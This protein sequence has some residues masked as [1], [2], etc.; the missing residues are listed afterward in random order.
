MSDSHISKAQNL[1]RIRDN[2]RRSR[3]RRKEYLQELEAKLRSCEQQGIEASAE[4]QSAARKV[5]EENKKLR[6]LLR[7][8][9]VPEAEIVAVM[10]GSND[11]PFEHI[12]AAPTLHNMLERKIACNVPSSIDS[13]PSMQ[14]NSATLAPRA[15]A[16]PPITI[17]PH[18]SATLNDSPSPRSIVSST[19]TPPAFSVNP[20]FHSS[21][22]QAIEVK[23]ETHI[24]QYGYQFEQPLNNSWNYSNDAHYTSDPNTYYNTSSCVDAANIIRT[25]RS[26]IGLELENELGCHTP[27]QNCYVNNSVVFNIMDK[28]SDPR[29]GI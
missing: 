28:Y 7:E 20:F 24:P 27:D 14:S 23:P 10:G 2:Q 15:T 11:K 19:G 1:A 26:D 4:I 29:T 25:M 22:T 17:P 3:A 13:P 5:L 21:M 8:R 12:S 18:R 6:A 9:G 16:V